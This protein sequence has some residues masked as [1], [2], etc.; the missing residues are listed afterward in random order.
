MKEEFKELYKLIIHSNNE[1]KMRVLGSVTKDMMC[2]L[3]DNNPQQAREYLNI[4]QSVKWNNYVT[5]KEAEQIVSNMKPSV[6]W[7]WNYWNRMIVDIDVKYEEVPYYNSYALYTTMSMIVSDSGKTLL[8][9][10]MDEREL[11]K[12]IYPLALDKLKDEDNMFNIR[13]YFKL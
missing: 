8:N 10:G 6:K 12:L 3:I 1:D 11:F 2:Q 5:V 13:S 9:L 4:L 7:D